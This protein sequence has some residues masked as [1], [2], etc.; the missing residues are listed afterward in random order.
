MAERHYKREKVRGISGKI[1]W[2]TI[3]IR[4]ALPCWRD[5]SWKAWKRTLR[6]C[7][8]CSICE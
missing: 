6:L 1:F 4:K 2:T 7:C 8:F 3:N 5:L